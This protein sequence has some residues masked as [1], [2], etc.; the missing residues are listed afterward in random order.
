MSGQPEKRAF[1]C[2]RDNLPEFRA[3]VRRWPELDALVK[4]LH[5]SGY[6]PG[7][8]AVRIELTGPS[9]VLAQGLGA[10]D[11]QNAPSAPNGGSH[12]A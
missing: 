7:L 9:E 11:F 12:E 3:A 5:S 4:D 6:L 8:R 1:A 2:T 10:I